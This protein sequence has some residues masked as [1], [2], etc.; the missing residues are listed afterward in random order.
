MALRAATDTQYEQARIAAQ[1]EIFRNQSGNELLAASFDSLAGNA[2]NAL[3]ASSPGACRRRR[4]CNLSPAILNS[5]INGF[6]QMG[7]EWV[8]S[9]VMGAAANRCDH[10][11]HWRQLLASAW[12]PAAMAPQ[13]QHWVAQQPWVES[14]AG[15]L[16][17]AQG[18]CWRSLERRPGICQLMYQV[19]ENGMPEIYQASNGS[20]Y[21]IPGDN[22]RVISNRDMQSGGSGG[23]SNSAHHFKSTQLVALTMRL[24]R[25]CRR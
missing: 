21:M 22:G 5:L 4:Q 15:S 16:L 17:S 23:G 8:K 1:W 2:S 20:Q 18:Y 13:L 6:V 14:Y 12:A 24:W 19:G 3:P 9:A 11:H 10:W 25:R 7:V